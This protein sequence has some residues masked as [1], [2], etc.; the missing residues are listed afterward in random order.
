MGRGGTR[1]EAV[2]I[3]I[4]R[5]QRPTYNEDFNGFT[6]TGFDGRTVMV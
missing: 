1:A 3:S 2:A 5:D 4:L 6:F